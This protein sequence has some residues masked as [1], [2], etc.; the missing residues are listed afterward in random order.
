M[1]LLVLFGAPARDSSLLHNNGTLGFATDP[2]IYRHHMRLEFCWYA[3][4]IASVV[5]KYNIKVQEL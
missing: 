5:R 3:Y 1:G 2:T 4:L